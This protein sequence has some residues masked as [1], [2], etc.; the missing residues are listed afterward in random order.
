MI[1]LQFAGDT[2]GG[3]FQNTVR[4]DRILGPII[5][6]TRFIGIA[7]LML[8][9]GLA[10]VAIVVNLRATVLLLPTGFSKLIP[11]AQG[12]KAESDDLS[13]YEPMSLAPWELFRPLLVGAAVVI[14][15]TLPIAIILGVSIHRMLEEQIAGLGNPGAGSDSF[16]FSFLGSQSSRS[17]VA[18]LDAVR[19]GTHLVL[20]RALLH[21]HRRLRPGP[22][23]GHYGRD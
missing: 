5:G 10:L 1:T 19:H 20:H 23:H 13:V 17:L 9:I 22:P 7:F 2:G 11:V 4:L 3:L 8:A 14:S 21:H 18:A 15:A 6:A 16:E 12:Q